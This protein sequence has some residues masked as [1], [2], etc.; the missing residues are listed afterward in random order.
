MA[1]RAGRIGWDRDMLSGVCRLCRE[2][3]VSKQLWHPIDMRAWTLSST[4]RLIAD[5]SMVDPFALPE[6]VKVACDDMVR[7]EFSPVALA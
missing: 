7:S 2:L 1:W 5:W 3:R 4:H 6:R